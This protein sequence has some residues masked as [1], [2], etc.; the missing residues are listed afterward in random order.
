RDLKECLLL[1]LEPLNLKGTLVE[2]LIANNL[3]EIEKRKFQQ[4]ATRYACSVEEIKGAVKIIGELEPKPGRGFSGSQPI[5]VKPDVYVVKAD[6]GFQIILN[7][8]NIPNI[9]INN[10]YKKLLQVKEALDKKEKAYLE[11]KLRSA[12]WLL[13]SLDQPPQ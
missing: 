12:V 13:K 9:R 7:D 2:N 6:D 5:Y 10:Y 8:D 4:L 11:D 1:Q 3:E